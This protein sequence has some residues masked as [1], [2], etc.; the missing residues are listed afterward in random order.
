[1]KSRKTLMTLGVIVAV[2]I[3]GVG[4]ATI[5]NIELNIN[6]TAAATASD[7]NFK[8]AFDSTV[9]PTKSEKTTD[10]TISD[11]STAVMTVE[12][13]TTSGETA[14]A[15]Y[16]IKNS[17]DDLSASLTAAVTQV[18]GDYAEY[19]EVTTDMNTATTVAAGNSTTITVTVKLKKTPAKDIEAQ[20]FKVTITAEPVAA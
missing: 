1:M 19:F 12:G 18:A 10:A 17:S 2:L 6:G 4:Y 7:D 11:D 13:L 5:S 15:T 9:T 20:N 16:T 8:V 3:L 14:T